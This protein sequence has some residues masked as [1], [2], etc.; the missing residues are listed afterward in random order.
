MSIYGGGYSRNLKV[1]LENDPKINGLKEFR[2][3]LSRDF[4]ADVQIRN[5]ITN[6]QQVNLIIELNCNFELKEIILFLKSNEWASE[7]DKN[8]CGIDL[9]NLE[10]AVKEL[11]RFNRLEVDIEEFSIFLKDSSIIIKKIYRES[12]QQQMCELFRSIAEHYR[13]ITKNFTETPYELYIPVFEEDLQENDIKIAQ[14][15][16]AD[17]DKKDYFGYW[18]L[19]FD[20]EEDA[21]IYDLPRK[22]IITGELHMLNH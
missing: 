15:E 4:F 18:G 3:R 5:R 22:R 8:C 12:I 9:S 11:N 13:Y 20:S 14:I 21:V 10:R 16:Q 17:N 1:H 19:Y 2:N 6:D 7:E